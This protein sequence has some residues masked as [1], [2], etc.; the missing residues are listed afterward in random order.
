MSGKPA[1]DA[2]RVALVAITRHGLALAG[3]L[4]QPLSGATLYA[5]EKFAAEV[6]PGTL[7]YSGKVGDQVPGLFATYDSIVAVVSL[8]AMVRLVAPHIKDKSSDPAVVVIDEGGRFVI[9]MLSGHL[10]GANALAGRLAAELG[11]TAVLT[12][13]S[14]AR[15]TLAVDL[16]GHEFGW[17]LEAPKANV[18]RACAAM[19]NDEPVV[20]V[21]ECGETTWWA[22]HA[23][24]RS[25]PPPPNLKTASTLEAL[26][27]ADWGAVLWVSQRDL[28]AGLSPALRD[29]LVAY[30]PPQT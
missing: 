9:P 19:V 8:G 5:P 20:L 30:R 1:F 28:P 6:P 24:G 4:L 17:R 2:E 25:G 18:T 14:D 23:N 22:G 3:R 21:Q 26:Q 29:K 16:L 13:A 27:A 12:T 11:A 15:Q 7:C 10:G